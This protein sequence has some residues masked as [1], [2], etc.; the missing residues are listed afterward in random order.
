MHQRR[1][2]IDDERAKEVKELAAKRYEPVLKRTRW[3]LLKRPTRIALITHRS[4]AFSLDLRQR[5]FTT[6]Y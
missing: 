1:T 5:A 4:S 2:T 6:G 3:L